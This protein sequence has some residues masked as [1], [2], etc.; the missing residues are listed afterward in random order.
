MGLLAKMFKSWR[1]DIIFTFRFIASPFHKGRVRISYDPYG[2]AVQ[3]TSDTGP[4]VFNQV[5]DLGSETEVDVRI[6]YQQALAWCYSYST[7]SGL[8][9]P[10]S[11]SSTPSVA[12]T[13]T[14]DNGI[15]SVKVLTLLSAPV[16]SSTINMQV[17][18]RGA[19]NMEF[20]NPATIQYSDSPFAVQSAEYVEEKMGEERSM[21]ENSGVIQLERSRV[22][23][24]ES[25]RSVRQLLRRANFVDA[26]VPTAN[27]TQRGYYLITQTR[28]PPAPGYDTGGWSS[29][30]GLVA[31]GSNFAINYTS[32]LPYHLISNCFIAQRGSMQWHYNWYGP[33][34]SLCAHRY[35]EQVTSVS[36]GYVA[37]VSTTSSQYD[38]FMLNGRGQTQAGTAVTNQKTNAGLSISCPNYTVFKFQTTSPS[39]FTAPAATS[40]GAYDGSLFDTVQLRL[41]VDGPTS[42]LGSGRLERYCGVGT[43][44]NLHFFLNC[45]T[46][47]SFNITTTV[48]N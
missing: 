26:I 27:D 44:F 35:T 7:F 36:R 28:F 33:E 21:G 18:V 41:S 1:G 32:M 9:T 30:K 13:D 8:N 42:D 43:D 45:P 22:H 3:T 10:Y 19:E 25:V 24:G 34:I 47:Y 40:S 12:Y 11:T 48:P 16:A 29:A 23:F 2:T 38:K 20:A 46:L 5:V 4:T 39:S 15:L 17:F 14:F 31:T 6:P 37:G